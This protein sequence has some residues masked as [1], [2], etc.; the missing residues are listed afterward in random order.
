[1]NIALAT[2]LIITCS[3]AA[4]DWIIE[5][6]DS[7]GVTGYWT[8]IRMD[9]EGQVHVV[10]RDDSANQLVHLFQDGAGWDSEVII[11]AE[12]WFINMVLD[13]SDSP[14]VVYWD[15][16]T[17]EIS[18]VH[19]N[20]STWVVSALETTV[21]SNYQY[22]RVDIELDSAG[23]PHV[24]W[25]DGSESRL[26]YGSWT[27]SSWDIITV[28]SI[29]VTGVDPS[30]ALDS[31]DNP[32]ISYGN[33]T[34]GTLNYA[35]NNGTDWELQVVDNSGNVD[36]HTSIAL[37]V[38]GNPHIS[39]YFAWHPDDYVKY[40]WWNGSSWIIE[41]ANCTDW[42]FPGSPQGLAL[43]TQGNAHISA[44]LSEFG[45]FLL[46]FHR[47]GA[48]WS[49]ELVDSDYTGWDNSICV[50]A[51]NSPHIAYF[52][53]NNEDLLYAHKNESGLFEEHTASLQ[54]FAL[55]VTPSP[56]NNAP[57]VFIS[58]VEPAL[59]ELAV[60]DLTGRAVLPPMQL[61]VIDSSH[62]VML[63]GLMTGIY[64]CRITDGDIQLSEKFAVLE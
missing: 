29:G 28:D 60:F 11:T 61:D 26:R 52:D 27:G 15:H 22:P 53:V 32:H 54:S 56:A 49:G 64:I 46:Y 42:V 48:G 36:G 8:S 38:N 1:M 12:C 58:V 41:V 55:C 33:N 16:A 57:S 39:Y 63:E 25:Y 24:A 51:V 31:I 44:E 21:P 20:D 7:E 17:S 14:H 50:D 19:W 40:A 5:T 62:T 23:S 43:D 35:F 6:L 47:D 37:D 13:S 59:L 4:D 45:N 3:L 9:S 18:Y 10:Y 34:D 2:V 30:L